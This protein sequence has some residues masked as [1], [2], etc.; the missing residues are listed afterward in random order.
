MNIRIRLIRFYIILFVISTIASTLLYQQ[1]YRSNLTDNVRQSS[2]RTLQSITNQIEKELETLNNYS[3]IVLSDPSIQEFLN[4]G[5][6]GNRILYLREA[7]RFLDELMNNFEAI[8]S[9]YLVDNLGNRYLNNK[10]IDLSDNHRSLVN[11]SSSASWLSE[12]QRLHGGSIIVSNGDDFFYSAPSTEV[13]SCMRVVND[14]DTQRPIGILIINL[15]ESFV[16]NAYADIVS[17]SDIDVFLKD[18]NGRYI[19]EEIVLEDYDEDYIINTQYI[20]AFGWTITSA[21]R[22]EALSKGYSQLNVMA[23]LIVLINGLTILIGS[24]LM[25]SRIT[26]PLSKLSMAMKRYELRNKEHVYLETDY[27]EFKQLQ[28]GFNRMT[29]DIQ[30][31]FDELESEQK[32]KR[33]AELKALQ[34]QIKPHFLYNT[35][36]SVCGLA[37][38]GENNAI[39]ELMSSLGQF[40]RLSLSKGKE[41]IPFSEEVEMLKHYL[42]IQRIRYPKLFEVE[43]DIDKRILNQ[44]FLKLV[45][46]PLVENALYHG[47][48]PLGKKGNILIKAELNQEDKKILVSVIDS[49]VGIKPSELGKVI[50]GTKKSFG[51]SGT[52]ERLKIY[53]GNED[54]VYVSSEVGIGTTIQ[55]TM[56]Y[57][58]GYAS[59]AD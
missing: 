7:E 45:L 31:L 48:K 30:K 53:S 54:V 51:L 35:F 52:I 3:R 14:L 36:D 43:Y 25:S 57:M 22:I 21:T 23:I 1:I 49:G 39:Y 16:E 15:T 10:E 38:M 11:L 17:Q 24:A 20:D 40:Y 8:D 6:S 12:I 33:K 9:F 59:E 26:R 29:E 34:A 46:Q 19:G 18:K 41:V 2:S 5:N 44:P 50:N 28:Y 42:L 58:E 55:I 13:V 4:Y 56:N 37:L 47:L 27:P 32:F